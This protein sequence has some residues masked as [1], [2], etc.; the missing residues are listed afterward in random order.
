MRIYTYITMNLLFFCITAVTSA[1]TQNNSKQDQLSAIE[2]IDLFT[3]RSTYAVSE[4]IY[5]SAIIHQD[6]NSLPILSTVVYVE[7]INWNGTKIVQSK[8]PI[9]SSVAHGILKIPEDLESGVYYFRAYTKWMRNFSPYSYTYLPL[10]IVNPSFNTTT[11]GP[12]SIEIIERL[13]SSRLFRAENEIVLSGLEEI[14]NKRELI[15]LDLKVIE[16]KFSGTY[17]L[18]VVR[19]GTIEPSGVS[20][21]FNSGGHKN[22]LGKLEFLPEIRGL[23]LSGKALDKVSRKP[24][25]GLRVNLSSTSNPFYYS[26]ANTDSAGIFLFSFPQ[27]TGMHEFNLSAENVSVGEVEL[28]VESDFCNQTISL[29]YVNFHLNELEQSTLRDVVKNMQINNMF[30]GSDSINGNNENEYPFFGSPTRTIYE[31]DYIELDN[32]QE[33]L[34][35]LVYEVAVRYYKGEPGIYFTQQSTLSAFPALVLMDNIKVN[36]I[37]EL[38]KVACR[39]IDRIEVLRKR[40]VVGD[41]FYSGI[42]SIHSERKDMVGMKPAVNSYFFN[43]ALFNS[44]EIR[45]PKYK[46]IEAQNN[47]I[48]DRRN[49]LFWEPQIELSKTKTGHVR[50]YT[51]DA[52]GD[53]K[54]ILRGINNDGTSIFSGQ[55]FKVE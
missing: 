43:M 27:L 28:L 24:I 50:F 30:T 18:S 44:Q 15:E 8:I 6:N 31:K 2:S 47:R 53:Y 45:F 36:N 7:L 49:T 48:P 16:E 19:T 14:Y 38:L 55:N 52:T 54:L 42:L 20:F 21:S 34:Y 4:N 39:R 3:D 26:F 22:N 5:Y 13:P 46:N 29:P 35:E 17:C 10:K 9:E 40:Y 23:S 37:S 12:K 1:Q 33:F 51:G 41:I 25:K 11:E 32:L